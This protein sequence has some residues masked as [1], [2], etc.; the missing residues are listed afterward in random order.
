MPRFATLLLL[1][2]LPA[3][4]L[5]QTDSHKAAAKQLLLV[6]KARESTEQAFDSMLPMMVNS[7]SEQYPISDEHRDTLA[8]ET[9][10]TMDF[11]KQELSWS[12]LEPHLVQLY[13][14]VYTE[15]ELR[16]LTDFYETPL[17]QAFIE[18]NPRVMQA[19]AQMTVKLMRDLAPKLQR[20]REEMWAEREDSHAH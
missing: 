19:S 15:E 16:G 18:K 13:V 5:A 9:Q 1:V 6:T 10:A 20:M 12:K 8:Q 7:M 11:L 3:A 2:F 14:D 4:L 17:G